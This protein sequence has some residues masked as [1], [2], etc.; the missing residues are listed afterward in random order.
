MILSQLIANSIIVIAALSTNWIIA[1]ILY[2]IKEAFNDLDIP[3][4]QAFMMNI[5]SEENQT[6]MASVSN[7]GRTG[8]HTFSPGV[9]GYVSSIFGINLSLIFG[10]SIKIIYALILL[11]YKSISFKNIIKN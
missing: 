8:A 7:L 6:Q 5:V 3:T 11:R 1:S 9:A 2:L 4:R 10:G